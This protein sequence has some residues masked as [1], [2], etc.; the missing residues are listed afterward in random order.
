MKPA[1]TALKELQSFWGLLAVVNYGSTGA[2]YSTPALPTHT[3]TLHHST[4]DS[5]PIPTHPTPTY[6][7]H[8]SSAHTPH[9]HPT[10]RR[11]ICPP[12]TGHRCI[13]TVAP[14]TPPAGGASCALLCPVSGGRDE[15]TQARSATHSR[16][17]VT[18]AAAP[19]ILVNAQHTHSIP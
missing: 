19:P 9:Q 5:P 1:I 17:S 8:N 3:H 14:S 10:H 12:P 4:P 11:H 16:D 15:V 13:L 6:T 2:G 7:L 18:R